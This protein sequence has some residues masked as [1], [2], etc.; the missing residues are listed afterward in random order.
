MR[1]A[2]L[3]LVL[4]SW[5]VAGQAQSDTTGRDPLIRT[6]ASAGRDLAAESAVLTINF[7]VRRRSPAEA[8]RANAERA[9]KIRQALRGLGLPEDSITTRGYSSVLVVDPYGRDTSFVA[10]NA[11][12]VHIGDL[13]LISRVIDTAL[14]EGAT[15]VGNL[16]FRARGSERA[17][18]DALA[19]ATRLAREQAEA[20]ARAAGGRVGRLVQLSTEAPTRSYYQLDEMVS[21]ASGPGTGTP[22]QAPTLRVVVTVHGVWA[23]IPGR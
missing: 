11:A 18:L 13:D 10:S 23:Y 7:S 6:S 4:V 21:S 3:L 14:V 16:Q 5:P 17:R 1:A 12:V 9:T 20:M 15:Q 22:I 19:D 2:L 8:G